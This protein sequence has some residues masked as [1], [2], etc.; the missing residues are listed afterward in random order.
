MKKYKKSRKIAIYLITIYQKIFSPDKGFL[1]KIGV[2]RNPVCVFY[3]TCSEYSKEAIEKYG[4][5]K[6]FYL[7]TKR[8]L[9]CHPWQKNKIDLL[10]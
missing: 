2:V 5:F 10:K 6:G 4:V 7:T 9:R 8:I 1:K 3:P